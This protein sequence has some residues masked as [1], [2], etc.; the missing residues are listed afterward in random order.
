MNLETR[1][2]RIKEKENQTFETFPCT[3]SN[4]TYMSRKQESIK[5]A[6]CKLD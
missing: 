3:D 2:N 4:K 6:P 5:H 1:H